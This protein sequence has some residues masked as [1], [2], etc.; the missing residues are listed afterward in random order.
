M[1]RVFLGRR[2]RGM[3]FFF[4]YTS[5]SAVFCFCEM[6]VSTRAIDS[7]TTLLQDKSRRSERTGMTWIGGGGGLLGDGDRVHLGELVG[8]TAGDLGDAEEAELVLEVLELVMKLR[9][10]LPPELVD[11]NPHCDGGSA[12]RSNGNHRPLKGNISYPSGTDAFFL[13]LPDLECRCRRAAL[14][15]AGKGDGFFLKP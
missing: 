12:V 3:C 14:G 11:L 5:L 10:R 4:L 7:L 9:P 8:G 13:G 15:E 2:S 6:T 1:A